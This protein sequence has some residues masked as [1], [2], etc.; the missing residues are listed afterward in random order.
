MGILIDDSLSWKAHINLVN[1]KIAKKCFVLTKLRN[2]VDLC[3]LKN[4]YYSMVYLHL[5]YCIIVWEQASK[6]VLDP[7]EKLHKRIVRI[8]KRR[9]FLTP[10]LP[11]FHQLNFLKFLIY[12][13]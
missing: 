1:S 6:C 4:F 5:Q 9:P 10:S 3:T 8:M 13:N 7:T 12:L 2:L 11:L